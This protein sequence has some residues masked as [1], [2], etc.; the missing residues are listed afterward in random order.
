VYVCVEPAIVP[1]TV[2]WCCPTAVPAGTLRLR[3]IGAAVVL[4][5]VIT[6]P[7]HVAVTSIEQPMVT[8]PPHQFV[9]PCTLI[10]IICLAPG[11]A[12]SL[13]AGGPWML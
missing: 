7:V 11:N 12:Q 9:D 6:P 1:V 2:N 3:F 10:G 8:D 5:G 4:P 13:F